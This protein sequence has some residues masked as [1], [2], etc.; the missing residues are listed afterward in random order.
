MN[1]IITQKVFKKALDK[2]ENLLRE[3]HYKTEDDQ[4]FFNCFTSFVDVLFG[5][6]NSK[7]TWFGLILEH[8]EHT[9]IL[10]NILCPEGH[11]FEKLVYQQYSSSQIK[12]KFPLDRLP[13]YIK[14]RLE[15]NTDSKSESSK[16]Y[17]SRYKNRKNDFLQLSNAL[18]LTNF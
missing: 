15:A 10:Y 9:N 4:D 8:P 11:F 3:I 1:E 18:L 2:M 17:A 6:K 16:F 14:Q 5:S 12:Y 7:E 13:I